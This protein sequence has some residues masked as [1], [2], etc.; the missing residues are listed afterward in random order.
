MDRLRGLLIILVVAGFALVSF[1]VSSAQGGIQWADAFKF[2]DAPNFKDTG[3]A[4][5]HRTE[6]GV[7]AGAIV[8]NVEP[9]AYTMWWLV[10]NT[11]EGCFEAWACAEPDLFNPKAHLAIGYAGGAEVAS[12]GKLYISSSLS[13]GTP[14][15]GFPY[16]EFSATGVALEETTLIDSRHAEIHLVIR[17]H[18]SPVPVEDSLRSFNGQCVYVDPIA[19][20]EPVYG[21]P[22]ANSCDDVYFAVFPSEDAPLGGAEQAQSSIGA[23]LPLT[24][25]LSSYGETSLTSLQLA[26]QTAGVEL[27]IEDTETS[28]EVALEKLEVL[29]DAGIRVVIGPYSSAEV[30]AVI[31]YANKNDM[32]LMSPLSTARTLAIPNDN[33]FRFTPDDEQEAVALAA[34]A[35]ERGFRVVVPISREDP[36]NLGLQSAFKASFE[37]LGGQVLPVTTYGP[38]TTDFTATIDELAANFASAEE[39]QPIA[40]YLTAF[41]EVT[42]LFGA[43]VASDAQD[44]KAADWLG[45]DS[46]ALSADLI[47]NPLAAGFASTAYYPNPILGL[48]DEDKSLWKPVSDRITSEISREPDAFALAAYDAL[49]VGHQALEAVGSEVNLD[50]IKR[51]I[52]VIADRY[53]GLTGSTQLNEA[54]DRFLGNYDFWSVCSREGSFVWTKVA[55]FTAMAASSNALS[56]SDDSMLPSAPSS[57]QNAIADSWSSHS[58]IA[59]ASYCPCV[60]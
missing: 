2:A 39:D 46:V 49:M 26:A 10:W 27:R 34:L 13:E 20:A 32:I 15:V 33:L 18:G 6:N 43:V 45:S 55:T 56:V 14:L 23:L 52:V 11:P 60:Q 1:Q 28:P 51:E 47:A 36:G 37:K 53:V 5:L 41:S 17:S 12:N 4:W 16:P 57:I 25:S 8:D 50:S 38:A 21:T 24:G 54:G 35:W 48:A 59:M 42:D 9:G 19:E 30:Q 29:H 58:E 3:D 31:D 40:V 44:L 22:G 7:S